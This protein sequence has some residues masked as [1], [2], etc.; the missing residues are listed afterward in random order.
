MNFTVETV[1][2]ARERI[3]DY[4]TETPLLR[5]EA[6]DAFL[7][8]QVYLKLENMQKIGVSTLICTDISR[9]GNE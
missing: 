6:L 4:V 7:G 3:R 2:E 8:C 5:M 1:K 9:D